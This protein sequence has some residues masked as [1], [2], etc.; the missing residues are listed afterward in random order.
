[1]IVSH[2][3]PQ[4]I[5]EKFT[6]AIQP[7]LRGS[8]DYLRSPFPQTDPG[9]AQ[10]PYLHLNHSRFFSIY[11]Q[12]IPEPSLQQKLKQFT[13]HLLIEQHPRAKCNTLYSKVII[14]E[15]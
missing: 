6:S 1:M 11:A 15:V 3:D 9:E 13:R 4:R 7:Q 12:T 8:V 14:R 5:G 2:L 10:S